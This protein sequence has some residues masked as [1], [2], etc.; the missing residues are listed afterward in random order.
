MV[1]AIAYEG[2]QYAGWQLQK[3]VLTVQQVVEEALSKVATHPVRVM[4]A[5]RT[6]QGVHASAQ[7]IHFD[8]TTDRTP[9]TWVLACNYYLPADIRIVWVKKT[10]DSFHARFSAYERSYRYLIYQGVMPWFKKYALVYN[11][12]L[13]SANMQKAAQYLIGE[14]DFSAFRSADCQAR[15]PI[16]QIKTISVSC[17]EIGIVIDIKAN[18]FLHHMVRNIVGVLMEMGQG[19]RLPETMLDLL[20]SRDRRQASMTAAPQ[21]LYLHHISYPAHFQLPNTRFDL[22]HLGFIL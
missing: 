14:H 15:S 21:G 10:L 6:D 13:N 8:T 9:E 1:C 3:G 11:R 20:N 12:P 22:P 2:T 19:R 17:T 16:R 18:A 5:G 7:T 4:C